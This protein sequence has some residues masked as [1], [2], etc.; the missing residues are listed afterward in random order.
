MITCTQIIKFFSHLNIGV[1]SSK[2]WKYTKEEKL[3]Q[4]SAKWIGHCNK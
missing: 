4:K 1:I 2:T 3:S